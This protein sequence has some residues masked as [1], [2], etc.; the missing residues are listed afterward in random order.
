MDQNSSL[1]GFSPM[2]NTT[3]TPAPNPFA[4]PTMPTPAPQPATAP[5]SAG[6]PTPGMAT[7]I[8]PS[9]PAVAPAATAGMTDKKNNT[10]IETIILIAVC[11]IAAIAIVFAVIFFMQYNEL[12]VNYDSDKNLEVAEAVKKQE[13]VDK[14]NFAEQEKL[15]KTPFT[16]PS[17]YGSI[18][19]EYPKTWSVYVD[20]DGTNN[21]DYKAYFRPAWVDPVSDSAS[22]Y[23]LRFQILNRQYTTVQSDYESKVK[24]GEMTSSVFNADSNKMTGIKYEGKIEEGIQGI[25]VLVKVNDKTAIFQMDAEVYRKDF[26]ELLKSLRR[27]S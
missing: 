20:S 18:S 19:F 14:A 13:D 3:P 27:N 8:A 6:V 21:S 25:V 10:L 17:D 11:V 22:R 2:N 15:P 4:A 7:P 1:G 16:G 26:E 24:N 5:V 12:K 9:A 23:A